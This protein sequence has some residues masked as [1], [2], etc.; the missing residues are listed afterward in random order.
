MSITCYKKKNSSL[1][2][3]VGGQKL[4]KSRFG[5]IDFYCL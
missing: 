4:Q 5:L 1:F 2:L 3:F